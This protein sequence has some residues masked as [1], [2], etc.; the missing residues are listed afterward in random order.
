MAK[1]A[2]KKV[3]KKTTSKGG[4]D[5]TA[6]TEK[7][8]KN[9][10]D[11]MDKILRAPMGAP[12]SEVQGLVLVF[13]RLEDGTTFEILGGRRNLQTIDALDLVLKALHL[14]PIDGALAM[15]TINAKLEQE[16]K[17]Q[18]MMKKVQKRALKSSK[19]LKR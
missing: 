1:K 14:D 4:K 19:K 17:V 11:S 15:A 7:E 16:A 18:E 13:R 12:E 5:K 2:V 3:A 10:H 9:I 6:Y 8:L